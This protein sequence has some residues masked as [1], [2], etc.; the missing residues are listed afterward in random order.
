MQR[1]EIESKEYEDEG[2]LTSACRNIS[3]IQGTMEIHA[4]IGI[5]PNKVYVRNTSCYCIN[6]LLSAFKKLTCCDGWWEVDMR[7]NDA[8]KAKTKSRDEKQPAQS[9]RVPVNLIRRA[10]VNTSFAAAFSSAEVV[11]EVDDFIAAIYWDN[12]RV[13]NG[14]V[15]DVDESDAFVSFWEHRGRDVKYI[16]V[17]RA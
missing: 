11:I 8:K 16:H 4:V 2:F 14:K 7:R 10:P 17:C 13:Y 9:T 5:G 15:T 12:G 3:P 1:K 6:C